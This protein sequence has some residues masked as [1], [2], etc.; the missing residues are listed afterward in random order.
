ME[1]ALYIVSTPIGNMGDITTRAIAT[2]KGVNVVAAEDTRHSRR[3]LDNLG[4]QAHLVS[5][6]E[7]NERE[8]A[9]SIVS[10]IKEGKSVALISDAGTPLISDPGFHLVRA[11]REQGVKVVPIPGVCA[12]VAGLSVSGLATDRFTFEGFLPAKSVSR[13]KILE[14]LE[15]EV[16]TMVF[17][18]SPH[19]IKS[20]LADFSTVFGA[21]RHVVLAREL[22]KK[23]ETV[24]SGNFTQVID[25]LSLDDNQCR[26]EFV[27][28]VEGLKKTE[29]ASG[30]DLDVRVLLKRLLQDLPVKKASGI[31]ADLTGQNKKELYNLALEIQGKR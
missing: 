18:E 21:D 12:I 13:K 19:R 2:L 3:L 24:L 1:A 15:D 25:I 16:R 29:T 14:T 28:I 20:S 31:A 8:K 7:H 6:H 4:I 26:G 17:Y 10:S 30:I 5:L 9:E 22:T 23:F 11:A 27:V